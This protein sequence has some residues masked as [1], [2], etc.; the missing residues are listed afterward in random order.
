VRL[1]RG[2]VLLLRP[3]KVAEDGASSDGSRLPIEAVTVCLDSLLLSITLG[4]HRTYVGAAGP[5]VTNSRI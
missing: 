4:V 1:G 5:T 3:Q 2:L